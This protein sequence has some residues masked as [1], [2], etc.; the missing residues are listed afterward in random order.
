MFD[1]LD[2]FGIEYTNEQILFKILAT[3]DFESIC[4]EEGSFKDTYTTK[5]DWKAYSIPVST[6]SN[7]VKEPIF[8]C[9]SDSYQLALSFFA[10]LE[11]L[12]LQ[13]KSRLKDLFCDIGT[14]IKIKLGSIL[15][16]LPNK[17]G[18]SKQACMIAITRFVP[19]LS[20]YR[21]KKTVNWSAGAFG[22]LLQCITYLW[23]QQRKIWS[24]SNKILFVTHSC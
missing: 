6:Y 10:A 20:F 21:S 3:I 23:F 16:N 14:T 5:K 13:N 17:I 18:E 11:N 4:V 2:F 8:L 1:R 24:Q 7:L 15:E 9:N 22:T 12:A 19:P